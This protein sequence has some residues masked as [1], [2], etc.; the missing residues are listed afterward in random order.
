ME[1]LLDAHERADGWY[2]KVRW[3]GYDS[4]WDTWEPEANLTDGFEDGA[5]ASELEALRQDSRRRSGLLPPGAGGHDEDDGIE[6]EE[7]E[8]P[9][10]EEEEEYEA[11][12]AEEEEEESVVLD[13]AGVQALQLTREATATLPMGFIPKPPSRQ[14]SAVSDA[15]K[16]PSRQPS[17]D[18]AAAAA[19]A[20][21]ALSAVG[22]GEEAAVEAAPPTARASLFEVGTKRASEDGSN[23]RVEQAPGGRAY[24]QRADPGHAKVPRRRR[25]RRPPRRRRRRPPR[26]RSQ[27]RRRRSPRGADA[28]DAAEATR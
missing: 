17:A 2:F 10:E 26:R 6:E 24:W 4:K 8:E 9:E 18:L 3:L 16:P 28:A 11:E 22:A 7:E 12:Q 15:P 13:A 5:G 14:S 23:W 1:K 19:A 20:A 25:S 21:A 27:S